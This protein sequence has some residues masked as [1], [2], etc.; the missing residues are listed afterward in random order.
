MSI[1]DEVRKKTQPIGAKIENSKAYQEA[2]RIAGD[3]QTEGKTFAR[4]AERVAEKIQSERPRAL[5]SGP[6]PRPGRGSSSDVL[7]GMGARSFGGS[8]IAFNTG[9]SIPHGATRGS[10]VDAG[11]GTAVDVRRLRGYGAETRLP[12]ES[13]DFASDPFNRRKRK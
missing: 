8:P 9:S 3:V 2:A 1:I 5:L 10:A 11:R 4:G 6:G 7:P 13:P 12:G